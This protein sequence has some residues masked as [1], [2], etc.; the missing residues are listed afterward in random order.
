MFPLI[1]LIMSIFGCNP[2]KGA[3]LE[4]RNVDLTEYARKDYVDQKVNYRVLKSGDTMSGHL[5]MR[6]QLVRGLPTDYP[7]RYAGDEA[8]SWGQAL[9]LMNEYFL[10]ALRLDGVSTM[11]GPLQ[12]GN[13]YIKNVKDPFQP[14]DAATKGYVDSREP[15]ITRDLDMEGYRIKAMKDPTEPQDAATKEYV[16]SR[17]PT[18]TGDL[19][20]G[21]YQIKAMKDPTEPQDAATKEYV[22]S[23]GISITEDLQMGDYRIK[24]IRWPIDPYDAVPKYYVDSRE[25]KITE[26]LIMKGYRIRQM[27]NPIEP[28]DAAT[29]KY[30]DEQRRKPLITVWA[31]Q[32]YTD[33]HTYEWSFG[34]N[35][36]AAGYST[37]YLTLA[38][39]KIIRMGLALARRDNDPNILAKVSVMGGGVETGFE[40]IASTPTSFHIFDYPIFVAEGILLNFKTH[41]MPDNVVSA[42]ASL[43][44]ELDL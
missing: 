31:E 9:G 14:Q 26:D 40:M 18:I 8:V 17:E 5:N 44:I 32:K 28:L 37:G 7:P 6:R 21:D 41:L 3:S 11:R 4:P 12:M 36:D 35:A 43:L 15:T 20:M 29:K 38:P 13:H 42:V 39:C 27:D 10:L 24:G 34:G 25:P 33:E 30:V 22:D 19:Q 2:T 23:R 1:L 16:D